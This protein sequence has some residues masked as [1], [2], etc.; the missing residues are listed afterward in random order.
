[1]ITARPHNYDKKADQSSDCSFGNVLFTMAGI[2]GTATN[3]NYTFAFPKWVNQEF[4]QNPVPVI[5]SVRLS[6]L[7]SFNLHK[8][9]QGFD[10]GFQGFSNIPDNCII[11]GYFG[12]WKY[13]DH[14]KPMIRKFF[15]MKQLCKPIKDKIIVH[16]RDYNGNPNMSILGND[17]YDKAIS[18]MP[19]KQILVVTDNVEKAYKIFGDNCEY[20]SNSPI[21]DFYLLTQADYLIMANSTFSW[22]GAYLSGAKTVAP[23][24]WYAGQFANC[25]TNDLYYKGWNVI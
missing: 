9:F 17:Y 20:T 21:I 1:M 22:W 6:R 23:K 14:C 7:R 4:F 10:V 8:N 5:D 15:T 13:F 19:K 18:I 11:S 16:Y 3:K 2:I 24:N 12:S 25:P